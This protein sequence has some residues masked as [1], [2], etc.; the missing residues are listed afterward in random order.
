MPMGTVSILHDSNR[1]LFSV[2]NA[3]YY[4]KKKE[5]ISLIELHPNNQVQTVRFRDYY[6]AIRTPEMMK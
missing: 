4:N 5:S 1:E 3:L 6:N 2:T